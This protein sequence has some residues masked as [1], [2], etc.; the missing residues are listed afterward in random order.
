M[1][2]EEALPQLKRGAFIRRRGWAAKDYVYRNGAGLLKQVSYGSN[3][4]IISMHYE[5]ILA[6]DWEVVTKE[7]VKQ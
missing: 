5:H 4:R 1:T 2:F 7:E 6:D 3:T